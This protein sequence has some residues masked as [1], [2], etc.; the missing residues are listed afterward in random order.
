MYWSG[1]TETKSHRWRYPAISLPEWGEHRL[2][3]YESFGLGGASP[4]VLPHRCMEGVEDWPRHFTDPGFACM[5]HGGL[6]PQASNE[7]LCS[8]ARRPEVPRYE[9]AIRPRPVSEH[10]SSMFPCAR[11]I[12]FQSDAPAR[13]FFHTLVRALDS[14]E[15]LW[16]ISL[17]SSRISESEC[18]VDRR[19]TG[20][21]V[22]PRSAGS[23]RYLPRL[24][25]IE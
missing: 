13:S 9:L 6:R 23:Q 15:S 14:C 11:S 21:H 2:L 4:C 8:L 12:G 20:L 5:T 18:S 19:S 16:Y 3:L 1:G 25:P 24:V 17:G 7:A 22:G 10:A